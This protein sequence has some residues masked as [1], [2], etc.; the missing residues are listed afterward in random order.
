VTYIAALHLDS[1]VYL[2]SDSAVTEYG[3]PRDTD[4]G[5]TTS[6]FGEAVHS[7]AGRTVREGRLKINHL[8]SVAIA[9]C[10]SQDTSRNVV[11]Q[12]RARLANGMPPRSALASVFDDWL[13]PTSE[14]EAV[15]TFLEEGQARLVSFTT[16][17][18]GGLAA[19][20]DHV[21]GGVQI[22]SAPDTVTALTWS[23]LPQLATQP[24]FATIAPRARLAV[25]LSFVQSYVVRAHLTPHGVGGVFAGLVCHVGGLEWQGDML[26]MLLEETGMVSGWVMSCIRGDAL[27]VDSSYTARRC[28]FG[29]PTS[30][31]RE[32]FAGDWIDHELRGPSAGLFDF[33]S[34]V[35]LKC[36]HLAVVDMQRSTRHRELHVDLPEMF[37]GLHGSLR[38]A[39]LECREET[40]GGMWL[41]TV[42]APFVPPL[43]PLG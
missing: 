42:F 43:E 8:G 12:M 10:G 5:P 26:F 13:E 32:A 2:L 33:V 7:E 39:L 4:A 17:T 20:R 14:F 1:C 15:A 36:W 27:V 34:L 40:P 19:L 11:R 16:H 35:N 9:C 37:F 6:S 28:V 21:D 29:T 38:A 24:W 31:P 41:R 22:G 30:L 25:L 18:D 3:P 23:S